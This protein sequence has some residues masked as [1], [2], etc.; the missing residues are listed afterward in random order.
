MS[1]FHRIQTSTQF[2]VDVP[3][4]HSFGIFFLGGGGTVC[5]WVDGFREPGCVSTCPNFGEILRQ[6]WEIYDNGTSWRT[7]MVVE[8]VV[9]FSSL[10][11]LPSGKLT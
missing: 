10:L 6:T 3:F 2:M 8:T 11:D 5:S 9:G 7:T 1:G 4:S